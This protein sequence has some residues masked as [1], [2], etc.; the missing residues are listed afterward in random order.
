M[1]CSNADVAGSEETLQS[2]IVLTSLQ[3]TSLFSF[4][5]LCLDVEPGRQCL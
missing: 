3:N 1:S 4:H 5:G 2:D